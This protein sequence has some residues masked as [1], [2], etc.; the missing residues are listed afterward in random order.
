[1]WD[2]TSFWINIAAFTNVDV[3][4]R[5]SAL[6]VLAEE[7]KISTYV[8]VILAAEARRRTLYHVHNKILLCNSING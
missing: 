7:K 8:M 3:T 5:T 2:P 1:L 6:I 4:V